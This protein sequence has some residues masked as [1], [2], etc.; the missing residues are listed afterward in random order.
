MSI[1]ITLVLGYLAINILFGTALGL[2]S[3]FGKI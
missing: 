3:H 1:V 2:L